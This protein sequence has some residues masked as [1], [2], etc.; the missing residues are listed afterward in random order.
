MSSFICSTNG[1]AT[2]TQKVNAYLEI[3]V[4]IASVKR[5]TLLTQFR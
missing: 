4:T 3:L 5:N 2:S 1:E